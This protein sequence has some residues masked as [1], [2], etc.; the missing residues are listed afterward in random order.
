MSV[1]PVILARLFETGRH[2]EVA[3]I[4][5]S[6]GM[7]AL[8]DAFERYPDAM[9]IAAGATDSARVWACSREDTGEYGTQFDV[10]CPDSGLTEGM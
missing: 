3:G 8:V 1:H 4:L 5:E 6:A 10:V 7:L 2:A 9:S